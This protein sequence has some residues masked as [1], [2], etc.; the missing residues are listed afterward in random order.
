MRVRHPTRYH[1]CVKTANRKR[2][3]LYSEPFEPT[4]AEAAK[5]LGVS[6]ATAYR[7]L[8]ALRSDRR[9]VSPGRALLEMFASFR[10][11]QHPRG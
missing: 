11:A 5:V 3:R 1:S 9:I 6:R 8:R 4:M 7:H 10:R 2:M